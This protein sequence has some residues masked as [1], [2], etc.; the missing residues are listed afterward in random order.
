MNRI[1]SIVE[2][3]H[4]GFLKF[5]LVQS[6][7]LFPFFPLLVP[8]P[9]THLCLCSQSYCEMFM[10]TMKR[11]TISQ[12]R[13][14]SNFTQ[15]IVYADTRNHVKATLRYSAEKLLDDVLL[16]RDFFT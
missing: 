7:V 16:T 12:R 8:I 14:L 15:A 6:P 11:P 1:E 4:V 5:K 13:L 3:L 9:V 10:V 2:P